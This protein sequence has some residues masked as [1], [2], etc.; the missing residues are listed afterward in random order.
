[1]TSPPRAAL[2]GAQQGAQSGDFATCRVDEHGRL[3]ASGGGDLQVEIHPIYG[4]ESELAEATRRAPRC[5]AHELKRARFT[6]QSEYGVPAAH[7]ADTEG[8]VSQTEHQIK[9]QEI[10]GLQKPAGRFPMWTR[11]PSALKWQW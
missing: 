3:S 11:G 5:R 4:E 2:G 6:P 10:P 8:Q 1:M 7:E 9:N